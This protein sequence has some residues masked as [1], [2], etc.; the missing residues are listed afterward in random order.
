MSLRRICA[1]S[2][3]LA[4][5]RQ[6]CR[7]PWVEMRH[8]SVGQWCRP[9]ARVTALAEA[10]LPPCCLFVAAESLSHVESVWFLEVD[11]VVH[12]VLA[13]RKVDITGLNPKTF[14][15]SG[16]DK[17]SLWPIGLKQGAG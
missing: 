13:P 7:S 15:D 1:A 16:L 8:L 6:L 12:S 11:G 10:Q 4:G 9:R 17:R 2:Y 5:H 14:S 3:V